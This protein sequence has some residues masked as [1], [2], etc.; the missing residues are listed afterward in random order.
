MASL[1]YLPQQKSKVKKI[2]TYYK[3]RQNDTLYAIALR[4][5]V[6]YKKLAALNN[7][8]S[9]YRIY[10][11]K[12]LRVNGQIKP[13][14]NPRPKPRVKPRTQ[15][16]TQPKI[17]ANNNKTWSWPTKGKLI[18]NYTIA[19]NGIKLSGA[20]G[21]AIRSTNNGVVVYSGNG[22][23]GYG[24]LIIIKHKNNFLSAYA[25]NRKLL[26]K[27]GVTVKGGQIIAEM[28]NTLHF[29]IRYQGKPVNP[30]KYL[31]KRVS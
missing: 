15:P 25:H 26:V 23:R 16:R 28:K 21:S 17:I 10:T 9:P 24:N 20:P 12:K 11:G 19:D 1:N 31:P 6:N 2:V 14:V 22:L 5:G 4:T 27:E 8:S 7:I 30:L 18:G 29:E 13:R 3:V